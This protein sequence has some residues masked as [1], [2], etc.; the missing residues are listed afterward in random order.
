MLIS[1]SFD[2]VE[3]IQTPD[4]AKLTSRARIDAL[5]KSVSDLWSAI[6]QNPPVVAPDQGSRFVHTTSP[7]DH[8]HS[9]G[10]SSPSSPANPPTHLLSLFDND[11][12]N[13]NGHETTTPSARLSASTMSKDSAALL[14]LLPP[15]EDMVTIA[16]NSES[17]LSWYKI[18]FS[19]SLAMGAGPM[20]LDAYDRVKR[21]ETHPV[22]IATL[23]LAV[24]L[25]VQQAQDATTMLRSIPDSTAFIKDVS[26]LVEKVV[27]S[28]DDLIAD[29]DGIR[30][31]LLFIRLQLG[32]ARVRKTWLT[33]RRVIAVAELIG[34]PRAATTLQRDAEP[35]SRLA[36]ESYLDNARTEQ[37]E[38][39]EVWESICAMDRVISM[40]WSLPVATIS[41]PLP[42]RPIVNAQGEVV[43][44]AFLHRLANIASKVLELDEVYLQEES[45]SDLLSIVMSTDQELQVVAN[46]PARS[47]WSESPS[48]LSPG[49]L[50]QY[51]HSY[52]IIRTHLRL[53]LAYDQE[54]RFLYNFISCLS[55][56]QVHLKRY[57]SLRPL[58]PAGFF[59]NYIV[60]LQAFSSIVF[61]LL[62]ANKSAAAPST[63]A[64]RHITNAQQT[65]SLV[66]EAVQAMQRASSRAGSQSASHGVEAIRSL[67]SLLEQPNSA[68]PQKASVLLPLIGRIH[69]SRKSG[70][71]NQQDQTLQSASN[72]P[73]EIH[74]DPPGGYTADIAAANYLGP[75]F[76]DTVSYSMEVPEDYLFFTDQS[77]D[78]EQWMSWTN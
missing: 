44:Q 78:T 8:H 63:V 29:L 34:L 64:S 31:A 57:V 19:L 20:M 39:A 37:K 65:H 15:R 21:S 30:S 74:R 35:R 73:H 18:L 53:A 1:S 56:C 59:A 48:S 16:A 42:V 43:L 76:L 10:D 26:N 27:V 60:D 61:L 9:S 66:D 54:Q 3:V 51:W 12:L 41:F 5:E 69:V 71:S 22:P 23:L 67:R 70:R 25:T 72:L 38:K 62:T 33:L 13:S 11:L 7:L 68:E 52:L 6:G 36:Y 17:W 75:E 47:W 45:A 24:T 55:A 58:L 49:A 77:F 32:R 46:T 14:E 50:F 4:A 28:N 2:S 40:M